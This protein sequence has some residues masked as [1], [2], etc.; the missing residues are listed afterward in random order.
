MREVSSNRVDQAMQCAPLTSVERRHQESWLQ[1][2]SVLAQR[3]PA[4]HCTSVWSW[5]Q[6]AVTYSDTSQWDSGIG[7]TNSEQN[8]FRCRYTQTCMR[9]TERQEIRYTI[10]IDIYQWI[11]HNCDLI[12]HR[13]WYSTLI[14]I[15]HSDWHIPVIWYT[16]VIDIFH[17]DWYSTLIDTQQWLTENSD[18]Y[19]T[20]IDAQQQLT[21]NSVWHT[22]V[23][24]TQQWLIFN[25]D[26]Y[27]IVIIQQCLRH[28]SDWFNTVID[29][30]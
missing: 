8:E 16:T 30:Q 4:C 7:A 5:E 1:L 10:V 26:W 18:C 2:S 14:D 20:A 21:H 22:T 27:S 12:F 29:S 19:T 25:S 13:D 9:N 17:R 24:D 11:T 6:S 15:L 23:I 3:L 28:N